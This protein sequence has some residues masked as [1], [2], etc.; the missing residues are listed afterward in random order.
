MPFDKE[1]KGEWEKAHRGERN[2][3]K[4]EMRAMHRASEREFGLSYVG[5]GRGSPFAERVR[6]TRE[7]RHAAETAAAKLQEPLHAAI[8]SGAALL[9]LVWW[10]LLRRQ[11]G[12]Q[13]GAT[14]RDRWRNMPSWVPWVMLAAAIFSA[15][16]FLFWRSSRDSQ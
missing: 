11:P 2:A 16:A 15:G 3:Q 13:P 5:F 14:V 1:Q 7:A 12:E 10:F 9:A 6:Q 8:A 4:R